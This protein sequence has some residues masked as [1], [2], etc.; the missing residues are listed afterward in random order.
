MIV[1][2]PNWPY[3]L[4]DNSFEH[5]GFVSIFSSLAIT[6]SG[7]L[8]PFLF[9]GGALFWRFLLDVLFLFSLDDIFDDF[10]KYN[11]C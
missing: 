5:S 10:F 1:F 4:E 8:S 6:P 3:L 9:G 2:W 11:F 7:S